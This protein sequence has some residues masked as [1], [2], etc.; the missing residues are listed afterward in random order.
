MVKK[1]YI[2]EETDG[3]CHD[4]VKNITKYLYNNKDI[5]LLE[6]ES[7]E[8]VIINKAKYSKSDIDQTDIFRIGY[9]SYKF[10]YNDTIFKTNDCFIFDDFESLM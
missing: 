5:L 4:I 7:I 1:V 6:N 10:V 3:I 2:I 8:N 9:G